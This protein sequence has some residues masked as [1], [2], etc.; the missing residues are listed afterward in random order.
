MHLPTWLGDGGIDG[1]A[2]WCAGKFIYL[3]HEISFHLFYSLIQIF[4]SCLT[5]F[6]QTI[7]A[8]DGYFAALSAQLYTLK[9]RWIECINNEGD[10]DET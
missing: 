8:V 4:H 7:E 6:I 3:I 5:C 1:F 2:I 10:D 9:H